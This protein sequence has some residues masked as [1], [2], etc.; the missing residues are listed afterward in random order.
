MDATEFRA[1]SD[2]RAAGR[3]LARQV[4][5]RFAEL[6][7]AGRPL[8]LAL[9][10]GGLPIGQEVAARINGELD[11]IV[12]RKVGLPEQ[13]ELGVGAVTADGPPLF[14]R[15]LLDEVGLTEADLAPAVEREREEARRRLRR[16]RA[17]R[18]PPEIRD[19]TVIVTDDGLA[20]GVTAMAALRE[21]RSKGPRH[22]WFAAP[23]CA[24]DATQ[25]LLTA[26]D[27]V[28]CVHMPERFTAVGAWYH[29]FAQLSD[30]DVEAALASE[31]VRDG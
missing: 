5:A 4:A 7:T 26:A 6:D 8:V 2:R 25:L 19:R 31:G 29:D 23:V 11:I 14:N 15:T 12:A 21:V 30:E 9:P 27:T 18:Q 28:L 24:R 13:P 10:R 17:G 20:T 16:Y 22:L 3:A 1:F